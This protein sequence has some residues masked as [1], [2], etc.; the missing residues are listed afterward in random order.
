M[1]T[2][3]YHLSAQVKRVLIQA[4]IS[5]AELE[6]MVA[7]AAIISHPDGNRRYHR[8]LMRV[9]GTNILT[10]RKMDY[11]KVGRGKTPM[12]EECALS[13]RVRGAPTAV[14]QAR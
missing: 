8:W 14:S 11:V 6:V 2:P 12:Y 3:T 13:V 7:R 9:D 5:L 10:L 4:E 1:S